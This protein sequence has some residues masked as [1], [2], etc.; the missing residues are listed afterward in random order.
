MKSVFTMTRGSVYAFIS[1]FIYLLSTKFAQ[2]LLYLLFL[3]YFS[4]S[5]RP[6]CYYQA[7]SETALLPI[8]LKRV[9]ARNT[10]K[11]LV[12]WSNHN[13]HLP[14]LHFN[15]VF[16]NQTPST[17]NNFLTILVANQILKRSASNQTL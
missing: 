8:F 14:H 10:K 1:I 6:L 7:N 13:S 15:S 9:S 11:Q 3:L 4:W 5:R 2:W 17:T 16:Q 12:C